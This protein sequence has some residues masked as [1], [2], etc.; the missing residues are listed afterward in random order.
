MPT[1]DRVK[2]YGERNTGTHFI[3]KIIRLNYKCR[4]LVGTAGLSKESLAKHLDGLPLE[5]RLKVREMLIDERVKSSLNSSFGWKHGCVDFEV[6]Q[7]EHTCSANTLFVVVH[8]HPSD[9]LTSFY[10]KPYNNSES[11][12]RLTFAEFLRRPWAG[13]AKE[14]LP[15]PFAENPV[16]LWNIKHKSWLSLQG[17]GYK[18][19]YLK[20]SDFLASFEEALKPLSMYLRRKNPNGPLINVTRATK[21]STDSISQLKLK[22]VETPPFAGYS[23]QDRMFVQAKLDLTILSKL[24]YGTHSR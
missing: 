3:A 12:R 20:N 4:Q 6:L 16:D 8:K 15:R 10:R 14:N 5:Q 7:R 23:E 11:L 17:R 24:G 22:Y 13:S 1:F 19:I 18:T 2:I 21:G 9:W